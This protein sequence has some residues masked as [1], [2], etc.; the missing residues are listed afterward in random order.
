MRLRPLEGSEG[1]GRATGEMLF[2]PGTLA[3]GPTSELRQN[4]DI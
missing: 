1:A 3:W 4:S 2:T